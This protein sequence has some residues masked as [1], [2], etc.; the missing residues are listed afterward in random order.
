MDDLREVYLSF[1]A[2]IRDLIVIPR[3]RKPDIFW[4]NSISAVDFLEHLLSED[5]LKRNNTEG[6]DLAAA[7]LALIREAELR[8]DIYQHIEAVRGWSEIAAHLARSPVLSKIFVDLDQLVTKRFCS[9]RYFLD[10]HHHKWKMSGN[11]KPFLS[12]ELPVQQRV[13]IFDES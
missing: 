10:G 8:Q 4:R 9:V 6:L 5:F 1:P 13:L 7:V 2:D 11:G 12:A 3:F